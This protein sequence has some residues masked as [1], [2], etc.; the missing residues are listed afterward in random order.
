MKGS[1]EAAAPPDTHDAL[2]LR[3]S[4]EALPFPRKVNGKFTKEFKEAIIRRVEGGTPL[5]RVARVEHLDPAMVRAWRDELRN[6][7][8]LAFLRTKGVRL[9]RDIKEAAVQRLEAGTPVKAVARDFRVDPAEVRRWRNAWR[10]L[11][12]AAFDGP[13]KARPRVEP[14]PR[15]VILDL[16]TSQ[17][18]TSI[19]T[20]AFGRSSS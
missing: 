7:G 18:I 6:L 9:A 3:E 10:T 2:V 5:R 15:F 17:T 14:K 12:H 8:P 4:D 11:G 16:D 13:G 1:K 19:N 20:S